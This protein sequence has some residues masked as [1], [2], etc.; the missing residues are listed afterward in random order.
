MVDDLGYS[1]LGCYGGE[2]STPNIDS[3]AYGGLRF[4]QMYNGAR[5]CP[6]R[7]A[8]LTGLHPHQAGIGQMT[9]DLGTPAFILHVH[10]RVEVD[11][12]TDM[13]AVLRF[14]QVLAAGIQDAAPRWN[15]TLRRTTFARA[16]RGSN[17]IEGYLVSVED[18]IAAVEGEEPFN[19][20][21]ESWLAVTRY[22]DAMTYVLQLARDPNFSM[23][24]GYI[25]SLHFMMLQYDLSK[26]PGNWRPGPI[27]VR[28]EEKGIEVYEAPPAKLIPEL[29][30]E[31]ISYLQSDQDNNHILVKAAMA[32]FNLVMPMPISMTSNA[33]M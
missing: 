30:Q 33:T 28:E 4:T 32:H 2:I 6:S 20:Q 10:D 9:T 27:W 25:R 22:R 19:A 21:R 14:E 1:D 8:L 3:L 31:L 7:A 18:A 13:L 12:E 24:E 5:C 11:I 26:N 23:N 17:S 29:I 16:I 15:G